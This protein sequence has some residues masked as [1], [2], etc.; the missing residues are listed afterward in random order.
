MKIE[1]TNPVAGAIFRVTARGFDGILET[2]ILVDGH[3]LS[4]REHRND[5]GHQIVAL[6]TLEAGKALL[7]HTN[8]NNRNA[9][10]ITL[11]ILENDGSIDPTAVHHVEI[12]A[13]VL[14]KS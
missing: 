10:Q 3:L 5:P 4:K 6:S 13:T 7:I 9:H 12:P 2:R 14:S 11:T 1:Y 8:L